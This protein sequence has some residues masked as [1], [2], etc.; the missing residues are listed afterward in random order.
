MVENAQEVH[1]PVADFVVSIADIVKVTRSGRVF[2]PVFP[3]EAEDVSIS[4]KAEIPVVN[5]VS[6]PVY[7]FSE[8]S[9]LKANDDDKVLKLIKR[10]GFNV[11]EQL[12]HHI[13]L[14]P[15]NQL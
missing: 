14:A 6:A 15:L 2:G 8:S 7:Q 9:K 5:P 11:V 12:L 3:K 4:K 1:L 10:S 13:K